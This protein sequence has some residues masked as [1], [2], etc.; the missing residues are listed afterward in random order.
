ML[1][2]D[3][4]EKPELEKKQLEQPKAAAAVELK[5]EQNEKDERWKYEN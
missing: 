2:W 1:S 5:D 4:F 3:E